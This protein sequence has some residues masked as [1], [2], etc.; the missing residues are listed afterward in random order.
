MSFL[1]KL[2]IMGQVQGGIMQLGGISNLLNKGQLGLLKDIPISPLMGDDVTGQLSAVLPDSIMGVAPG[3]DMEM[4][5]PD[6]EK[7]LANKGRYGDQVLGHLAPGE[8]VIPKKIAGDPEFRKKLEDIYGRYDINIDQFTVGNPANSIN[9]NTGIME[10]G[11][12][13]DL[14]GDI[15]KNAPT[16]GHIV[17]FA[18]GGPIGATIGG[19]VGGMVKEGDIGYAAKQAATGFQ[20]SNMAA[21]AGLQGGTFGSGGIGGANLSF[22]DAGAGNMYAG[23]MGGIGDFYQNIGA[24]AS[25]LFTGGSA[26]TPIKESFKDLGMLGKGAV[27]L[28][29][30]SSL[31]AFEDPVTPEREESTLR[32]N[33]QIMDY[34]NQGMGTGQAGSL[35]GYLS[36]PER[37]QATYNQT[38]GLV[39]TDTG[40]ENSALLNYLESMRK[41]PV[42]PVMYPSFEAI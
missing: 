13:S 10:Y 14:W 9:P 40:I 36:G 2:P 4:G 30:A 20:L 6:L 19:A 28:M 24:N 29:G 31:G 15:K 42:A 33:P 27:G 21:G 12:L 8:V 11:F 22:G 38:A 32:Q 17:G 35:E 34:M 16:I 7:I 1:E 41:R 18:F 23:D 26:G 3:L 39:P 5:Q 25:D 37:A